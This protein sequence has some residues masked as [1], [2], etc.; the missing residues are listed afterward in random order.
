MNMSMIICIIEPIE[1]KFLVNC[2]VIS[3]KNMYDPLDPGIY[4]HVDTTLQKKQP[5]NW[6]IAQ[7]RGSFWAVR[8]AVIGFDSEECRP[9]I[10]KQGDPKEYLFLKSVTQST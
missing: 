7:R 2:K 9:Q 1:R 8:T 5:G 10:I 6:W 4:N 3:D